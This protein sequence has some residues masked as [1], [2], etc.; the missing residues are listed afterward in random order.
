MNNSD[1]SDATGNPGRGRSSSPGNTPSH[2]SVRTRQRRVR[3]GS[4][5]NFRDEPEVD[6]VK[7]YFVGK[8]L[9]KVWGQVSKTG[10]QRIIKQYSTIGIIITESEVEEPLP[11]EDDSLPN[12]AMEPDYPLSNKEFKFSSIRSLDISSDSQVL[13]SI[14]PDWT[15]LMR[16]PDLIPNPGGGIIIQ[17][18]IETDTLSLSHAIEPDWD[19]YE[20][21]YDD[22]R[23]KVR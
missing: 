8:E 19:F 13:T 10:R 16:E 3:R 5:L 20:Y 14:Q 11:G 21:C 12:L 9:Q 7:R 23:T 1:S 2:S 6:R 4:H 17:Y 15:E 18:I 22:Y